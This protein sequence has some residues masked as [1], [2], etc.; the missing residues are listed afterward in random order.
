MLATLVAFDTRRLAAG[1]TVAPPR[2]LSFV[3]RIAGM[4]FSRILAEASDEAVLACLLLAVEDAADR[5]GVTNEWHPW[6]TRTAG[7]LRHQLGL[8]PRPRMRAPAE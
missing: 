1:E 6:A 5:L 2:V 4:P 3:R 8:E 7:A